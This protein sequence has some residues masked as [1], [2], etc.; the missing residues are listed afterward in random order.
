VSGTP[1]RVWRIDRAGSLDRLRCVEETLSP[2]AAG[3]VRLRVAAVGLNFADAFA[4]QG[5]YSATPDGSFIPGL[6]CAGVVD[7]VGEG[8]RGW[9]IGDGA[10]ALTRFGGYA[11]S[12]NVD[13]RYL[14]AVPPGWTIEQAAAW[15]VQA[16]TAWYGLVQLG[17]VQ[18]GS[19]VLVQSAAGGVGLQ[20]LAILARLGAQ[21]VAVIGSDAKREFL[22]SHAG[23]SA[24]HIVTRD[25]RFETQLD[26]ALRLLGRPGFDVV[27]DAVLGPWFP[28][29]FA[30]LAPE[31][32][33]VL[34]GAADFMTAG[35]KPSWPRLAWRWLRR[36]RLDPLAMIS[37][38]RG[39]LAFNLIW[40][41]ES[42]ARMPAAFAALE[43]LQ[44]PPPHIGGRY[45]F[46]SA[47][48]ALAVLQG[49][50]TTGKL[51]LTV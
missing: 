5:L 4:C 27:F 14:H 10:L 40:L 45:P 32:R 46:D 35:A 34:Y 15:P 44:L 1:R 17:G 20:A 26:A 31:G 2:P 29:S 38:N 18:R 16:L 25:R 28:P 30:R 50:A 9:S 7:A 49:G 42:V 3:E 23:L 24:A 43:A 6:E 22:M 47:R 48:E 19:V 51:L 36:P 37:S 39:L 8:V 12:L 11:T 33:Y 41:W 13:A 21:P